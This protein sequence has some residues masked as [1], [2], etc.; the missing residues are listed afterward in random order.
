MTTS[1]SMLMLI[2]YHVVVSFW[3]VF[4]TILMNMGGGVYVHG[5]E[6]LCVQIHVC[7]SCDTIE[8][9]ARLCLYLLQ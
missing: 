2:A 5:P 6:C 3:A 4:L 8:I 9:L 7:H 1:L